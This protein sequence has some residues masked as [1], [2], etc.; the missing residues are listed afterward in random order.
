MVLV[1]NFVDQAGSAVPT[2][3]WAHNVAPSS[4]ALGHRGRLLSR[5]RR[6]QC[7]HDLARPQTAMKDDLRRRLPPGRRSPPL[8]RDSLTPCRFAGPRSTMASSVKS[9]PNHVRSAAAQEHAA[10]DGR[11][12]V[13]GCPACSGISRLGP[14]GQMSVPA[15]IIRRGRF[16]PASPCRAAMSDPPSR[17]RTPTESRSSSCGH[18]VAG[19]VVGEGQAARGRRG[20]GRRSAPVAGRPVGALPGRGRYLIWWLTP[21]ARESTVNSP[22]SGSTTGSASTSKCRRVLVAGHLD[23]AA[24]FRDRLQRPRP[25]PNE[26]TSRSVAR[27]G[28]RDSWPTRPLPASLPTSKGGQA[29]GRS[30]ESSD[31]DYGPVLGSV[32]PGAKWR[33]DQTGKRTMMPS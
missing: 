14:H 18:G 27:S 20:C 32:S 13:P 22:A 30:Q 28:R 2:P 11:R 4:M 23:T 16:K 24:R 29:S 12:A 8:R 6:R 15:A 21:W 31:P 17:G 25:D 10:V 3:F 9:T 33:D 5:C 26:L 7:H 19:G 1:T